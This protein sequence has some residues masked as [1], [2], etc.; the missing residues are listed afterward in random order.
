MADSSLDAAFSALRADDPSPPSSAEAFEACLGG[1]GDA[2]IM[3][4]LPRSSG[5]VPPELAGPG[6]KQALQKRLVRLGYLA[7]SA[8][9]DDP[10]ADVAPDLLRAAVLAF[11]TEAGLTADGWVGAETWNAL[12]ELFTFEETFNAA[13][14]FAPG[15]GQPLPALIRALRLRLQAYGQWQSTS[16]TAPTLADAFARWLEQ[17]RRAGWEPPAATTPADT[18]GAA[19]A[20]LVGVVVGPVAGTAVDDVAI[21]PERVARLFDHDGL[22]AHLAADPARCSPPAY[23]PAAGV[24][25]HFLLCLVKV[26][27]WLHGYPVSPDGDSRL[28]LRTLRRTNRGGPGGRGRSVFVAADSDF[29]N[30]LE[31]FLSDTGAPAIRGRG[32]LHAMADAFENAD[33]RL[34]Q[35]IPQVLLRTRELDAP[36]ASGPAAMGADATDDGA[37]LTDQQLADI[38]ANQ[39]DPA[40]FW[41]RLT[42]T[43][44]NIANSLFDGIR[45]AWRWLKQKI[46]AA[47]AWTAEALVNLARVVWNRLTEIG[48]LVRAAIDAFGRGVAFIVQPTLAG[49]DLATVVLHHK[50]DIDF[51][52]FVACDATDGSMEPCLSGLRKSVAAFGITCNLLGLAISVARAA[53]RSASI[54]TGIGLWLVASSLLR[55]LAELRELGRQLESYMTLDHADAP[56]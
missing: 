46:S 14:W 31:G 37:T 24:M 28:T 13:R 2:G 26:E 51:N 40:G 23:G 42:T 43:A 33:Q 38:V 6:H 34:D 30:V 52:V 35:L 22:V 29:F 16:P 8:V 7:T 9:P 44:R 21:T 18:P 25:R 19:P 50:L 17:A 39:K 49:S 55:I 53:L 4:G 41:D 48:R 20:P 11:Q 5:E 27:L 15:T 54:T 56:A 45:R 12:Q 36:S 47:L 10:A 3:G 32:L 1:L